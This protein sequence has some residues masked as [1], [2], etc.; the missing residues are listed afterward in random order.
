MLPKFGGQCGVQCAGI[1]V[2]ETWGGSSEAEVA[3]VTDVASLSPTRE[4]PARGI[5]IFEVVVAGVV[6]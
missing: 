2:A 3:G 6:W 1:W 4:R 5:K